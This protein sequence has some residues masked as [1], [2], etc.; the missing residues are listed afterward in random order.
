MDFPYESISENIPEPSKINYFLHLSLTC[1]VIY[2]FLSRIIN[3]HYKYNVSIKI[4]ALFKFF[5]IISLVPL[6]KI[7]PLI[8]MIYSIGDIVLLV[9]IGTC[10]IFFDIAHLTYIFFAL[11]EKLT[12]NLTIVLAIFS[13]LIA[14]YVCEFFPKGFTY[15]MHVLILSLLFLYAI[16]FKDFMVLCHVISDLLYGL[17]KCRWLTWPIYYIGMLFITGAVGF[18]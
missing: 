15:R 11:G 7:N 17:K 10:M 1:S 18:N 14:T 12:F 13:S 2:W 4:I 5:S 8:P 16:T 6:T 3:E 9:D